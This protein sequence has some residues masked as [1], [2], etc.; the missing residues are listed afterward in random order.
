MATMSETE[1]RAETSRLLFPPL[2]RPRKAIE[3]EELSGFWGKRVPDVCAEGIFTLDSHW[4]AV[5]GIEVVTGDLPTE[6]WT[7]EVQVSTPLLYPVF[8]LDHPDYELTRPLIVHV[9]YGD[10]VFYATEETFGASGL[11]N[12]IEQAVADL[13]KFLV[14]DYLSY[15]STPEDHLSE[16]ALELLQ[17][18][19]RSIKESL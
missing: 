12:T 9:Q 11:G 16:G 1:R 10:H 6:E 15:R 7:Y 17:Q 18:Y 8:S 4:G 14:E 13:K 2:P 5:A 19:Q 3:P